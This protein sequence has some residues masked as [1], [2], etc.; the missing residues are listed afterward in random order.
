LTGYCRMID[1]GTGR[2]IVE[3]LEVADGYWSRLVGLQLRATP[4][5]G[6]GLLL[7]PCSS[8]H[9]CLMRFPID[10]LALDRGGRIIDVRPGVRPW[11]HVVLRR[12]TSAVVEIP[13]GALAATIEVGAVLSLEIEPENRLR[14]SRRLRAWC[15]RA[16]DK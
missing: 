9:T 6:F 15:D 13:S 14:I 2:S 16:A 5:P 4:P 3:R 8:I 1:R 11:R 7:V 12:S 10:I